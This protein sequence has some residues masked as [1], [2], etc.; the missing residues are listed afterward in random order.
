MTG[1]SIMRTAARTLL[2]GSLDTICRR[3]PGEVAASLM[4]TW[5]RGLQIALCLHRVGPRPRPGDPFPSQTIPEDTLDELLG[6]TRIA[7]R[8]M[9][10]PLRLTIPFD[11]GYRDA[12]EY[13]RSRARRHPEIEWLV[14]V[15]PEKLVTRAGFRWD[16]WEAD[17]LSRK[18]SIGPETMRNVT[19][20][21]LENHRPDLRRLGDRSEF[22][23]ATVAECRG[24]LELP[25]VELGNHTNSHL[26]LCAVDER[27]ARLELERSAAAFVELFGQC[28]HFAFPFGVPGHDFDE[29]HVDALETILPG[30]LLWTSE[31]RPYRP[32]ERERKAPL[33]RVAAPG[34]WSARTIAV[35]LALLG[36]REAVR[37][38]F[39]PF[40]RREAEGFSCQTPQR[41]AFLSKA[42]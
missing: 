5:T 35:W 29:A 17:P 27:A 11:D 9:G 30:A 42:Y 2:V 6:L 26:S 14:F 33:P 25:G 10:G 24:L 3:L 12:V 20:P 38:G 32:E 13:V 18:G 31:Q 28:A 37:L 8:T 16:L 7:R 4:G 40:G 39:R 1:S 22:R 23:L 34:H 21:F 19:H 36:K 41:R 15:C